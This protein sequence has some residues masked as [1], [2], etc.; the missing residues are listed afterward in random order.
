MVGLGLA[1]AQPHAPRAR[2]HRRRRDADGPRRA[3]HHR[4]AAAAN[5]SIVVLDNERYGETGMQATHTAHGIDLAPWPRLRDVAPALVHPAADAGSC[6]AQPGRTSRRSR[7]RRTSSRWASAAE[8]FAARGALPPRLCRLLGYPSSR[9]ACGRTRSSGCARRLAA[10]AFQE[11]RW[12][13]LK[14]CPALEIEVRGDLADAPRRSPS[15]ARASAT[16]PVS[17][18][19]HITGHLGLLGDEVQACR[20]RSRAPSRRG[21]GRA[22]P[23]ARRRCRPSNS[24]R[25]RPCRAFSPRRSPPRRPCIA[26]LP[27]ELLH[28]RRPGLDLGLRV[29]GVVVALH[30]IEHRRRDHAGSRRR[31]SRRRPA[32]CGC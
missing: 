26:C 10:S 18:K 13:Q 15:P 28:D 29:A 24:R 23:P 20:R 9:R 3:R 25:C 21:P 30:A 7:C 4:R 2:G 12:S 8:G 1:L 27:V 17:P 19:W 14:P 31:R 32:G 11:P 5:L 16:G 22:P 6:T